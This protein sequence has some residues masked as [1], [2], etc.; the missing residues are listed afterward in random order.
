VEKQK[1]LPLVRKEVFSTYDLGKVIPGLDKD[2]L[3][4]MVQ[5]EHLEIWPSVM[6]STGVGTRKEWSRE[7]VYLV[8]LCWWLYEAGFRLDVIEQ[9]LKHDSLSFRQRALAICRKGGFTLHSPSGVVTVVPV[10]KLF[11]AV[12]SRMYE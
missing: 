11:E 4:R 9:S 3:Q 10:K 7:D 2:W 1:K 6:P 12:E 8:A 5:D